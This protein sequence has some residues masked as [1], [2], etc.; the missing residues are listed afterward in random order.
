MS[1]GGPGTGP[2]DSR[3]TSSSSQSGHPRPVRERNWNHIVSESDE[4]GRTLQL[5]E[6]FVTSGG[7]ARKFLYE[8]G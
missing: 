2:R 3:E 6:R 4:S 7:N 8:N 5:L 1:A